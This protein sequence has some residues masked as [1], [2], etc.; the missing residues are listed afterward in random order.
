MNEDNTMVKYL[1]YLNE[2]ILPFIDYDR[3]HESYMTDMAYAKGILNLLHEAKVKIYGSEHLDWSDGDDGYVVIPGVLR[4]RNN[5]NI[6]VA[7]FGIDLQSSGEHCG[8]DYLYKYGIIPQSYNEEQDKRIT[9]AL[10][11]YYAP[12]DYC[13]TAIIERDHHIDYDKLP[14]QIK[15]VLN[16]FHKHKADLSPPDTPDG[17]KKPSILEGV[18]ESEKDIK[19]QTKDKSEKKKT[20]PEH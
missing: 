13:Y 17:G 3:L 1:D 11:K 4:G 15:F 7:L 18:R 14:N 8:T 10:N 5:G 19:G 12:Y 16:S 2:N 6:C 9:D 20:E